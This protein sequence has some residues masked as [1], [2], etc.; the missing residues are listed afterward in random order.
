MSRTRIRR[1][2]ADTVLSFARRLRHE[3]PSRRLLLVCLVLSGGVGCHTIAPISANA[4]S[5][6]AA[7][8][9]E[10]LS[11]QLDGATL[12]IAMRDLA[13]VLDTL[14]SLERT[15][16][17]LKP[18][19]LRELAGAD[20]PTTARIVEKWQH[21]ITQH[22]LATAKQAA[23]KPAAAKQAAAKP[24]APAIPK[25]EPVVAPVHRENDRILQTVHNVRTVEPASREPDRPR[26][27]PQP[28]R[29]STGD[30]WEMLLHDVRES[31]RSADD[32]RA[33]VQFLAL[34]AL[35][36]AA[37][38]NPDEIAVDSALWD[39]LSGAFRMCLGIETP[40][41]GALEE[42]A[43]KLAHASD[44]LRRDAPLVVR[45]LTLCRQI[46]G[47]G[48]V[49]PFE[50]SRFQ[51]RQ[52]ILL[53]SEVDHFAT[54]HQDGVYRSYIRSEIEMVSE[55]GEVVW[56][57]DFGTTE[58]S[59]AVIRRDYFLSH[60]LEMPSDLAPAHYELRLSLRDELSA[61]EARES[62]SVIIE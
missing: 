20:G 15:R 32:D 26:L 41:S 50:S 23:A 22:Q 1:S 25:T 30:L 19:M 11:G 24:P 39:E 60:R 3:S 12:R 13:I 18:Q 27:P 49:T 51:R 7:A 28:P 5:S 52:P 8:P 57:H 59:C 36:R 4:L 2:I 58:D 53:Y 54:R 31:A 17:D 14:A 9:G 48:S 35:H 38:T 56:R 33:R 6:V 61:R 21:R 62:V 10:Q 34:D 45:N 55:S 37:E 40:D 46:R 47:F 29:P 43:A 44:R 16:P 42:L